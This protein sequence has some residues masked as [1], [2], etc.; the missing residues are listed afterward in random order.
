MFLEHD[1][2]VSEAEACFSE[3]VEQNRPQVWL[4]ITVILCANTKMIIIF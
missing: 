2:E 4:C 1:G 3:C